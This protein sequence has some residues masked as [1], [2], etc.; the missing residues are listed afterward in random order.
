MVG[1]LSS[2]VTLTLT[3]LVT[4]VSPLNTIYYMHLLYHYVPRASEF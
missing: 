3:F 1:Y 2:A 4:M